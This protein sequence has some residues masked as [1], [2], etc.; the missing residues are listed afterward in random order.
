MGA[1]KNCVTPFLAVYWPVFSVFCLVRSFS[2]SLEF[3]NRTGRSNAKAKAKR[4]ERKNRRSIE[5]LSGVRR[6]G[7]KRSFHEAS[8][9][10]WGSCVVLPHAP[11][12][13][14]KV[15]Y[16]ILRPTTTICVSVTKKLRSTIWRWS[17]GQPKVWI[18]VEAIYHIYHL[19]LHR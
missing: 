19:H 8:A 4:N 11:L 10:R 6:V 9:M 14:E 17:I 12:R 15:L 16:P 7:L 3:S 5:Q 13:N 2:T 18:P 1:R